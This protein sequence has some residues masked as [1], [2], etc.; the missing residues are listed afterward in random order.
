[1][2][3]EDLARRAVDGE[4]AALSEL[5]R[6]LETPLFALCLRM[7]GDVRD[8]EDAAQDVLVKV[9]THL[10]RFEGRSLLTTWVHQI[11]VRHVLALRKSRAELRALPEEAFAALLERG[12]EHAAKQPPVAP[13]DRVLLSEVR[14]TCT[15]GMLMMLGREERLAL[16]LV[17]L[18]GFDGAEAATIV[19]VGHD[20]F[21]QRL[22]RARAR[23]SRFLRERCGV[24]S[25]A[26]ACRCDRQVPAKQALGLSRANSRLAPLACGDLPPPSEVALAQAE[27]QAVRS[28]ATAFH[29]GALCAPASLRARME[30]LLPTLLG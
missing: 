1:M 6:Q 15:Q 16:V 13:D 21:R 26:A 8:A 9:V 23:L 14:L 10:S 30:A 4:A 25:E 28:I 18:L 22:S 27:L 5:C 19:E 7:L 24:V 11:A 2:S 20:A 3:L 12:L 17:D 29:G